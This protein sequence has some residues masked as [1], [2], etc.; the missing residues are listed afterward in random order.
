[1]TGCGSHA[2]HSRLHTL[3]ADP[4]LRCQVAGL[5]APRVFDAAGT[6]HGI[7]FGGTAPTEVDRTF[8]MGNADPTTV[9]MTIAACARTAGWDATVHY[10]PRQPAPTVTGLKRYQG[11][12]Q[13]SLLVTIGRDAGAGPQV[14]YVQ[15]ETD[16]V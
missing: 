11:G 16:P 10:Y 3:Q 6:T 9:V 1:M 14:V 8:P 5:G 4:V 7:G 12:W 2:N 13:A 15:I